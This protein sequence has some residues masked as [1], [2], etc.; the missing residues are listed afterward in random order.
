MITGT[1]LAFTSFTGGSDLMDGGSPIGLGFTIGFGLAAIRSPHMLRKPFEVTDAHRENDP[2]LDAAQPGR[3]SM[4]LRFAESGHKIALDSFRGP[5]TKAASLIGWISAVIALTVYQGGS[6]H[7]P[8]PAIFP[9]F[10]AFAVAFYFAIRVHRPIEV[11]NAGIHTPVQIYEYQAQECWSDLATRQFP[12]DVIAEAQT[13]LKIVEGIDAAIKALDR[14]TDR[15]L[16]LLRNAYWAYG[17]GLLILALSI[18]WPMVARWIV[19]IRHL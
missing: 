2:T 17:A 7:A 16:T 5:D 6:A 3:L 9:A 4:A 14:A 13:Q 15:K 10:I 12:A 18:M 1:Y 11:H 19:I 8:S